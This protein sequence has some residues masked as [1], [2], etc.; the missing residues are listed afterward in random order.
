MVDFVDGIRAAV[1]TERALEKAAAVPEVD[2]RRF[3]GGSDIAAIMGVG[4]TFKEA[5]GRYVTQTPFTVW[6]KKTAHQVEE[7]DPDKRRFL[8]RRKRWEGPIRQMLEEEF[9]AKI[10][11]FNQRYVDPEVPFFASEIDF[12]WVDPET[13]QVENGEIK[14]VS[15]WAYGEKQGWGDPGTSDVPIHYAAQ[16]MWGLGVKR[17][18]RC[19]LAAMVGLDDILFYP[20]KADPVTIATM[21]QVAVEF[22]N[23]F[24]VPRVPP[25]PQSAE[26]VRI[27]MLRKTGRPVEL[28]VVTFEKLQKLRVVRGSLEA[29]NLEEDS[30]LVDVGRFILAGWGLDDPAQGEDASLTMGGRTVATWKKQ[31]GSHL[32]QKRLKVE[33]PE[34][35]REFTKA[36]QYRVLRFPKSK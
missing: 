25:E 15:P 14:T 17:R 20:I 32:D 12:E 7:M 21:R 4:G 19:M 18:S 31:G 3:I 1:E 16:A 9:D 30:L 28:D 10:V 2:R 33:R 29:F 35:V 34:I 5:D 22:W 8:D 24:V 13:G 36:H 6:S 27:Q 11:G 26:D 23:R